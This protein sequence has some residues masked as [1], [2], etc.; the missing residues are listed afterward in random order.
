MASGTP[1]IT[2]EIHDKENEGADDEDLS[3][4]IAGSDLLYCSQWY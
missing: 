1:N 3:D 2:R 4:E